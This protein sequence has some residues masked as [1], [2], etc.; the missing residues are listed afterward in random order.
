MK[1]DYRCNECGMTFTLHGNQ[2][3]VSF[4]AHYKKAHPA[5]Y[6]NLQILARAIREM[7]AEFR[8]YESHTIPE[9]VR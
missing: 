4:A 6:T 9:L 8:S 5:T 1:K 2:V 7:Q 3:T